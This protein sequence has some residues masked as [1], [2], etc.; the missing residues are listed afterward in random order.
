MLPTARVSSRISILQKDPMFQ[1]LVAGY[2]AR[3]AEKFD[4]VVERMAA[5]AMDSLDELQR[6][7][8]ETPEA[9]ETET[10]LKIATSNL[11]RTGHAP[12]AKSQVVHTM[13]SANDI[14]AMKEAARESVIAPAGAIPLPAPVLEHD[15]GNG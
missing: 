2:R 11:D 10:L 13:L 5:L 3:A 8:D 9:L 6:R 14:L 4:N 12:V 15:N 7:I 1:E